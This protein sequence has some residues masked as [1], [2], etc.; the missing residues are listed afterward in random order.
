[1]AKKLKV[2]KRQYSREPVSKDSPIK[3]FVS[4]SVRDEL[5]KNAI[6]QDEITKYRRIEVGIIG[7]NDI[8]KQIAIDFKSNDVRVYGYDDN[9]FKA[10]TW[11]QSKVPN[12]MDENAPPISLLTDYA[13]DIESLVDQVTKLRTFPD[14]SDSRQTAMFIVSNPED[15][16]DGT[17]DKL[18]SLI[19]P[20]DFIFDCNN[21]KM[22]V[23]LKEDDS[24]ILSLEPFEIPFKCFKFL[25]DI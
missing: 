25:G 15:E 10:K 18:Q 14:G 22:L 9:I 21:K 23:I 19:N 11:W 1:M 24:N 5:K 20:G 17:I 6:V 12:P 7:L 13:D 2:E 8:T 3:L 16:L 4:S